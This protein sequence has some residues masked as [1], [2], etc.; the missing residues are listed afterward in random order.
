MSGVKIRQILENSRLFQGISKKSLESVTGSIRTRTVSRGRPLIIPRTPQGA[1]HLLISGR[2]KIVRL[3]SR[4]REFILELVEPGEIF[5]EMSVLGEEPQDVMAEAM[6]DSR[7]GILSRREFEELLRC[8]PFLAMRVTRLLTERRQGIERRMESLV[9]KR[10]PGRLAH[11]LLSLSRVY[12][13]PDTR[14]TLLRIRLSQQDLG[15][16]I[17]ASREIVNL[18]LSDFRRRGFIE[19][20]GRR[21]ILRQL[22]PLEHLQ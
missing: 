22:Q 11:L 13:V 8:E 2:L 15:N 7:V 20:R 19:T 3:S 4:G 18:T 21:L 16:F 10:V 14:G 9:F 12:G 5:G 1:I 17:G 6:E